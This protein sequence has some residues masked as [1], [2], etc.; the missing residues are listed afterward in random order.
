MRRHVADEQLSIA[1]KV[2]QP[3]IKQK[4]VKTGEC[5]SRSNAFPGLP[6]WL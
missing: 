6:R 4:C 5:A 1:K 3:R 2:T